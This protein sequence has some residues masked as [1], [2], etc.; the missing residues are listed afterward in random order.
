MLAASVGSGTNQPI[1]PNELASALGD[2]TVQTLS[3][4]TGMSPSDLLA[5]LSRHLPEFVD[6]LTPDGRLPTQGEAQQLAQSGPED[7]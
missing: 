1:G 5:S 3:K 6:R 4:Q 2:D 7:R